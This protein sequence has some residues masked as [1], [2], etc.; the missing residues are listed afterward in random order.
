MAE[1]IIGLIRASSD[2]QDVSSQKLELK[3]FIISKNFKEEDII[4]LEAHASA[5]KANDDYV[6][7]LQSIKDLCLNDGIR[8]IAVWHLNRLART[9]KYMFQ[10][11]NFF[12]ENKIQLYCK[13]PDFTLLNPDYSENSAGLLIFNIFSE[14][15]RQENQER[16][17]KLIRGR[18]YKK[19]QKYFTGGKVLFGYSIDNENRYHIEPE[20]ADTV[21]RIFNLYETGL[22]SG[23]SIAKELNLL[24]KTRYGKSWT[25]GSVHEVLSQPGYAGVEMNH[26][27]RYP[28]IITPEQYAKVANMKAGNIKKKTKETKNFAL[29]S[30]LIVCPNCGLKYIRVEKNY[31]CISKKMYYA[32]ER[33]VNCDSKC[34]NAPIVEIMMKEI[35]IPLHIRYLWNGDLND[36]KKTEEEIK[37]IDTKIAGLERIKENIKNKKEKLELDFYAGRINISDERYSELINANNN[38]F[39]RIEKEIAGEENRKDMLVVRLQMNRTKDDIERFKRLFQ[40]ISRISR[41]EDVEDK[42]LLRDIIRSHISK[43][44]TD[45]N[46]EEKKQYLYFQLEDERIIKFR[47]GI[48]TAYKK[49]MPIGQILLNDEWHDLLYGDQ[50]KE[51]KE[52][53]YS[54]N[55]NLLMRSL[56]MESMMLQPA[57]MLEYFNEMKNKM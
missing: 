40:Q 54:V 8:N 5:T 20:D 33:S 36:Q 44:W 42:I 22:H 15:I 41:I 19:S 34:I 2:K 9:D 10:M 56:S 17:K 18:N 1:R 26:G 45:Y 51:T 57:F 23:Y 13:E 29:G 25:G 32:K 11:K 43:I 24:G 31:L 3:N 28:Q 12:L 52:L 46:T 49:K 21:M 50:N 14:F 4:W 7:L 6:N 27:F 55:K 48:R 35:A 38:E 47:Y 53:L 39:N 37:D 30:G 16:Q